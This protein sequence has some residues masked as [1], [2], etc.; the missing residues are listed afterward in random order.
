MTHQTQ[1]QNGL[2]I[3]PFESEVPGGLI[4]YDADIEFGGNDQGLRPKATM[5]SALASCTGMDVISLLKKM[6]ITIDEL[7]IG[8]GLLV[9]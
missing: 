4:T 5:L 2:K 9:S 3:W 1:L 7:E 8:A 6:R